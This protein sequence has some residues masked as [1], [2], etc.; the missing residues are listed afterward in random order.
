MI[1]HI[2]AKT[3]IVSVIM[4]CLNCSKYLREAI[5]SVYAQ[6][7]KDWEIIF[8]DNASTDTSGDIANSYDSKLRYFRGEKTVSLGHARNLA[9]EKLRGEFI[10]FLDC[11]DIWLPTKLEKQIP[12][13]DNPKV[14]LVFCNSIFFNDKGKIKNLYDK[15]KPPKG[16]VFRSILTG[17]FLSM[18]T[19]VIRRRA[20][21]S[22]EEWFDERF[23]MAEEGDLFIRIAHSWEFDYI[24]EPLSKWRVHGSNWS[25]NKHNELFSVE[26]EMMIEKY[27]TL[28]E[29]FERDYDKELYLLRAEK[30]YA[31]G[32]S[33]WEK[34]DGTKLR[35]S[36]NPYVYSHKKH[37]LVYLLSLI[38]SYPVF[39]EMMKL[40]GK[41]EK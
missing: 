7:Y 11:D 22:L 5:D 25:L 35:K 28:Y 33:Q 20:L 14:G 41:H 29:N 39:Y 6:T 10:A 17:Y 13:F 19:V 36:L 40:A 38:I 8:W 24:D 16:N 31:Y 32:L 30:D 27:K 21:E 9:I 18:E 1:E 26:A 37:L 3:P 2:S 15:R 12:L 4:N 34:N 23:N